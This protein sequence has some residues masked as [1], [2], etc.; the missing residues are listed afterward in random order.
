ME[1]LDANKKLVGDHNGIQQ[2]CEP[3]S[4]VTTG[5][6]LS[7]SPL[8]L[9]FNIIGCQYVSHARVK[10]TVQGSK[11]ISNVVLLLMLHIS[12]KGFTS[13]LVIK[14]LQK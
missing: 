1:D 13:K 11:I 3:R 4:L 8:R 14:I 9:Q 5:I 6:L 12:T 7:Y 2:L 10:Y